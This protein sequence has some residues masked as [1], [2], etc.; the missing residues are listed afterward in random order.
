MYAKLIN[1][2]LVYAPRKIVHNNVLYDPAPDDILVAE[3]Y[4]LVTH[5]NAPECEEL[6]HAEFHWDETE[7]AIVQRW[8]VEEDS[9][10]QIVSFYKAKLAE[11]DYQAI[12]H[13]E[14]WITDEEYAPMK[15]QRQEWRD[16]INSYE[17]ANSDD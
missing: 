15:A 2:E 1:N 7:T 12:K 14:G 3:G 16:I 6:H 5:T 8:T 4:K 11:T 10:E 17:N 9:P 13:S